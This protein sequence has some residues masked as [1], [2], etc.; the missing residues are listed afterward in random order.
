MTAIVFIS[1]RVVRGEEER[2]ERSKVSE[3]K[4]SER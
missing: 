4:E 2:G 3:K 1:L